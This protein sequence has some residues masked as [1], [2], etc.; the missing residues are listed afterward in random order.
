MAGGFTPTADRFP[1]SPPSPMK[2][3]RGYSLRSRYQFVS[4]S[5]ETN[6]FMNINRLGYDKSASLM[7]ENNT[8]TICIIGLG[9]VGLPTAIGFH[10]AGFNVWGVDVSERIVE[11]ILQGENPTG[12]PELDDIVPAVGAERRNISTAASEAVPNCDCLVVTVSKTITHDIEPEL[13]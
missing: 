8:P 10:D 12:D 1:I 7:E 2:I 4:N 13:S 5:L 11:T 3:P 6:P 9:Y